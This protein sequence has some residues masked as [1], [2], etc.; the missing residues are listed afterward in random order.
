MSEN[1]ETNLPRNGPMVHADEIPWHGQ[2][3]SYRNPSRPLTYSELWSITEIEIV[4]E[5]LD[6][7]E[8]AAWIMDLISDKTAIA[9][10]LHACMDA[11][12]LAQKRAP[13][14]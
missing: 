4:L 6:R 13:Q 14:R 5:T 12:H 11:L 3:F 1:D 7:A 2:A 9:S 8:T 10:T